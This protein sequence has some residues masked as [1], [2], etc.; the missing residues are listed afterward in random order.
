[1]PPSLPA[2]FVT[3]PLA[4]RGYHNVAAGRPE[5][6]LAAFRAAIA[7]GYG[8]ELDLQLTADGAAM[9]FH[10]YGLERLTGQPGKLID[11]TETQARS[12]PLLGGENETIPTLAEA[13]ELVDGRVPVL[14]EIKDQDGAMGAD[15]GLLE[16]ATATALKGYDG[17]VAVMSF[18]PNSVA[19]MARLAP[20]VPRGITTCDYLREAPDLPKER[21]AA[22]HEIAD[23]D[24]VDACFI[25]HQ[26]SDL[27]RERVQK[28]RA[29]GV[30]VLCWTI[31]SPKEEADARRFADNITFEGYDPSIPA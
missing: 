23:F 9:V 29:A 25:S 30:P 22:L 28:I 16:A 5:N 19:E 13:L 3:H 26:A 20:D 6:S 10:D 27:A 24:Q 1:M 18:N 31:K 21:R 4:H 12:L 7:S 2:S 11:Q 17:P 8:I 15:I 14:I